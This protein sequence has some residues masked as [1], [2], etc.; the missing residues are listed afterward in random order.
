MTWMASFVTVFLGVA[1]GSPDFPLDCLYGSREPTAGLES[2]PGCAVREGGRVRVSEAHL[3]QMSFSEEGLASALIDRQ[4]YYLRRDG[5][6][7]PVLTYDNGP[8][9]FSEGLTRSLVDGKM[10]YFDAEL[11][12]VVAP[13]YDWGWP[14]EDGRALVCLGCKAG[15]P[16]GDGHTSI[17]GGRWSYID[18][19]GTE[20]AEAKPPG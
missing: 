18:K 10:A 11:R 3:A 15:A 6:L 5:K 16:D 12:Q 8:D 1:A 14:F 9:S 4:W 7:L 20:V 13:K 17:K 19:N 2:H